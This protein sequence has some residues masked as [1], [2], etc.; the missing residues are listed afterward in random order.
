MRTRALCSAL[1][2]ICSRLDLCIYRDL[3][4]LLEHLT[5]EYAACHLQ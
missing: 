2:L 5:A 4:F 1:Y 3:V